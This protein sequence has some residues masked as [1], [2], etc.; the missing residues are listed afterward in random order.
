MSSRR[1]YPRILDT[2]PGYSKLFLCF[3]DFLLFKDRLRSTLGAGFEISQGIKVVALFE[4]RVQPLAVLSR[5]GARFRA[6]AEISAV[7][8]RDLPHEWRSVPLKHERTYLS[9]QQIN[10]TVSLYI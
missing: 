3:R 8:R 2:P 5:G 9:I 6:G 1:P 4:N 10:A 7:P